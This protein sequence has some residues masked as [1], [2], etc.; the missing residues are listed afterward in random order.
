MDPNLGSRKP[1]TVRAAGLEVHHDAL[2]TNIEDVLLQ[3]FFGRLSIL[4]IAD[5]NDLIRSIMATS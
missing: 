3:C 4:S 2:H 1:R 5:R